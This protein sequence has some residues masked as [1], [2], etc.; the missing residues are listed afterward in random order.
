[1]ADDVESTS[2]PCGGCPGERRYTVCW[3]MRRILVAPVHYVVVD[4]TST[5]T[6]CLRPHQSRHA[7]LLRAS[8]IF[9]LYSLRDTA[10]SFSQGQVS[11]AGH[12]TG[13]KLIRLSRVDMG[14]ARAE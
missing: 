12:V 7:P 6:L 14:A 9:S 4:V 11:H 2:M 1:V 10:R 3:L 8:C 13:C 5:G